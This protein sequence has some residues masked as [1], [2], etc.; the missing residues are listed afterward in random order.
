MGV[1][2]SPAIFVSPGNTV[3]LILN[4]TEL[5]FCTEGVSEGT[6]LGERRV[7]SV[8]SMEGCE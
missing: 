2:V 6:E 4:S 8:G 3:G 5:K 7:A 1:V